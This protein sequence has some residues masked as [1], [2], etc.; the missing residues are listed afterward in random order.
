MAYASISKQTRVR[1]RFPTLII[2][3]KGGAVRGSVRNQPRTDRAARAQLRQGRH[4]GFDARLLAVRSA[5]PAHGCGDEG[6][7]A[8]AAAAGFENVNRLRFSGSI[9]MH[10]G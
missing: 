4:R 10:Q 3:P 5:S 7:L 6:A 9:S 1:F 2:H 8:G